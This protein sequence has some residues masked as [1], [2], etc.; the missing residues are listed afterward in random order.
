V[1]ELGLDK[2]EGQAASRE[3][4]RSRD[5]L[6]ALAYYDP[7]SAGRGVSPCVRDLMGLRCLSNATHV[8]RVPPR[9]RLAPEQKARLL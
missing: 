9:R 3:T 4:Q 1:T 8:F 7:V 5:E 6:Q 2:G